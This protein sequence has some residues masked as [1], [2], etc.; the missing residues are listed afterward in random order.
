MPDFAL[1]GRHVR[2]ELLDLHHV[3]GLVLAAAVNPSLYQWTWVPQGKTEATAY[4]ETARTLHAAGS[5]LPF[6]IV[7]VQDEVVIG[8]TRFMMMERWG[9]P[10]GHSRHNRVDPDVTEIG[11]T[12]LTQSAI[13]SPA[14]TEA[15]L[16]MLEH[17]FETWDAIRVCF[18]TD[19][20]NLR[21]RAALAR[22]G[23][24]FEG[25]IRS[26]RLAADFHVRDSARFSIL[27]TEWPEVKQA[28]TKRL[29]RSQP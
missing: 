10:L 5:A 12:W 7:R 15:K 26:D 8:S 20:R 22:I 23:G 16:L 11:A 2:L 1:T 4:V 14:N 27:K 29:T 19:L 25:V 9:W 17:A 24:K 3:D 13:R 21:S 6:A 18:L 28:L